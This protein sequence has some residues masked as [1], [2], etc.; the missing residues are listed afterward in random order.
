M[1][2]IS[3][4]LY[5]LLTVC[6]FSNIVPLVVVRFV[7]MSRVELGRVEIVRVEELIAVCKVA[8]ALV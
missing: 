6:K 1:S 8:V 3:S 4:K 5:S 2:N 7:S